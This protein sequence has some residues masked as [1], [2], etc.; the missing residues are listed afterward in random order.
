MVLISGKLAADRVVDLPEAGRRDE[1]AHRRGALA[2]GYRQCAEITRRNGTTYYWGTQL[3]PPGAPSAR[4]RRV[5]VVPARRRHRRRSGRD[6]RPRSRRHPLAGST[7]SPP[8][9]RRALQSGT[10]DPVLA[11]AA[12][13][14]RTVGIDQECFDRFFGAMAMDLTTTPVRDLGRPPRL[15]GGLRRRHRRDDA[16]R[17]CSRCGRGAREP[18]RALGLRLPVHELPARR[19]RG[20]RPRPGLPTAGGAAPGSA[21]SPRILGMR[22]VTPAVARVHGA[23]DRPHPRPVRAA[24]TAGIPL[25]PPRSARCVAAARVL[26]SRILDRIEAAD[27]DVFATRVRVPTWR[28]ATTAARILVAGPPGPPVPPA[29]RTAKPGP[30]S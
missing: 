24:R 21:W 30:V 20:P 11:A 28:K 14:V 4:A 13:T 7:I 1:R 10:A 3:L 23:R 18:A 15:H 6:R 26:Y 22:R 5:R 19:R 8:R 17:C 29:T 2:D 25:L 16:A 12:H 9:F 27:Y